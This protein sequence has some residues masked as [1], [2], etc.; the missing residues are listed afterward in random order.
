MDRSADT[1][2]TV[3]IQ[4]T[5]TTPADATGPVPVVM[6]YTFNFAAFARFRRTNAPVALGPTWQQQAPRARLGYATLIPTTVQAD[7]GAGF[8]QGII[9]LMN[10]GQPRS[11]DDW[12]VLRAFMGLGRLSRA[13][14]YFEADPAVDARHVALEGHSRYG[15]A[16]IVAMAYEPRLAIA[17]VSS[18]GEGGAK[19]SR[20]NW[21]ETVENLA[22]SGEYHWMA[23]NFLKYAGPLTWDDM[24]VD[25]HELIAM[26]APRPCFIS[27]GATNGDSWVD[28]KGMFMAAAAASPV[29]Q[30]RLGK[31]DLGT[32]NFPP[33]AT[34]LTNGDLAFRQHTGPHTDAPNWPVFLDFAARYFPVAANPATHPKMKSTTS[35][36]KS[37]AMSSLIAATVANGQSPENL[38]GEFDGH[39]DIGAPKLPE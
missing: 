35:L 9:G 27:G 30:A 1:N 22:G 13:L 2:I 28:A 20:R 21:G 33:I 39:S 24:P 34:A 14:D 38:Y 37:I 7:N 4:L 31:T 12:G 6:Q 8:A 17:Y 3:D 18:S 29:Y 23:G 32:T 36:F 19:L 10:H 15:K 26:C 16:T 5:L 25:S 11:P